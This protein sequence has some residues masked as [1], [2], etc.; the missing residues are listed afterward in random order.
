MIKFRFNKFEKIHFDIEY[1]RGEAIH[2]I[3]LLS[4]HSIVNHIPE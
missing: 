1:I 4:N 2:S 3:V